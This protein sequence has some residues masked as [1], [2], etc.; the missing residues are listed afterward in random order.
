MGC[1]IICLVSIYLIFLKAIMRL[2]EKWKEEMVERGVSLE[3]WACFSFLYRVF[4]LHRWCLSKVLF[5]FHRHFHF[6]LTPG[7]ILWCV[8][9]LRPVRKRRKLGQF[10]CCEEMKGNL[11]DLTNTEDWTGGQG[12]PQNNAVKIE[13]SDVFVPW[14]ELDGKSKSKNCLNSELQHLM[15]FYFVNMSIYTLQLL[16]KKILNISLMSKF[17]LFR[18]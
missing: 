17:L 13:K 10:W 14:A 7:L 11:R 16:I 5:V 12:R 1:K 9:R 18:V 4:S 15:I 2:K 6:P 8:L 3:G